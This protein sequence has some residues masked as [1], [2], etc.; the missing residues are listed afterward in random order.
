MRAQ[1]FPERRGNMV[2]MCRP[3]MTDQVRR[4]MVFQDGMAYMKVV[5]TMFDNLIDSGDMPVTIG[6]FVN[7]GIVLRHEK[8]QPR[9]NRSFEFD[10]VDGRYAKFLL[11]ELMPVAEG[12]EHHGRSEP[13]L[14]GPALVE[15]LP[16][17]WPGSVPISSV[18]CFPRSELMLD[19]EE[20]TNCRSSF[21]RQSRN[22]SGSSCRAA[23]MITTSTAA[24]GGRRTRTCCRH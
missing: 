24:A 8:A 16:S 10:T 13:S 18:A 4:L 5:P 15:L 19:Y 21:A 7:P 12:I 22:R 2:F 14:G 11:E 6:L 23:R 20:A 17:P 9:Y 1:F 3:S